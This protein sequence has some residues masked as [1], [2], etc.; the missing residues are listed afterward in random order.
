VRQVGKALNVGYVLEGSLQRQGD[1]VRVVA[2]LV[3]AGTGAHVWTNRWDRPT[4]DIFA[5]QSEVADQVA[6]KLGGAFGLGTITA[7]EVQRAK[8]QPPADL[9]APRR[10]ASPVEVGSIQGVVG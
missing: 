4:A 10:R 1:R 5:V 3:D 7:A 9:S 6:A 8:R 2:Q